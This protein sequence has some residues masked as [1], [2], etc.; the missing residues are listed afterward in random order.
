VALRYVYVSPDKVIFP[1]VNITAEAVVNSFDTANS[2]LTSIGEPVVPDTV[3][4]LSVASVTQTS[5]TIQW[6]EVTNGIGSPSDYAVR[7]AITPPPF[8]WGPSQPTEFVVTGVTVG[9]TIQTTITGLTGGR[10]PPNKKVP[11]EP[12]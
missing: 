5:I 3:T 2:L 1:Q 9:N 11:P 7:Y 10:A 12:P 4:T 6:T 8:D